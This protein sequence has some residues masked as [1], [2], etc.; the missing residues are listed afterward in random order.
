MIDQAVV[1]KHFWC[2]YILVLD[3]T[4]LCR[5]PNKL[6]LFVSLRVFYWCSHEGHQLA[7][8]MVLHV[9]TSFVFIDKKGCV[10]LFVVHGSPPWPGGTVDSRSLHDQQYIDVA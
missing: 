6:Q 5:M 9:C 10:S 8:F 7:A 1:D 4:D 3:D 2:Q